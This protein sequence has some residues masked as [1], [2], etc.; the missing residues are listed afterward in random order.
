MGAYVVMFST[1][2]VTA[3]CPSAQRR[4]EQRRDNFA[5]GRLAARL[6]RFDHLLQA[7]LRSSCFVFVD[8]VA[9][10][11]AVQFLGGAAD[12]GLGFF[13]VAGSNLGL[14]L[15]Q[16]TAEFR[17]SRAIL[18]STFFALL[19]SLASAGGVG[20]GDSVPRVHQI[21][22]RTEYLFRANRLLSHIP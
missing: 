10:T 17:K 15:T 2:A 13:S 7:R 12:S 8:Q 4:A 14:N 20:H 19:K 21:S 18:G 3:S 16:Q 6:S 1:Q 5:A 9:S 22:K 11:C